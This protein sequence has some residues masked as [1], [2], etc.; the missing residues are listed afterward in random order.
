MKTIEVFLNFPI[1]DINRNAL[2][3]D[4][5]KVDPRQTQRLT[6]YWG[7]DTWR[8]EAYSGEGDLFGFEEK[9]TNEALASAFRQRLIS[10]ANFAYVPEPIPMRNSKGAVVYYLYFASQNRNGAKIV[11]AIFDKYRDRSS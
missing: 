2:W 5:G 10:V 9:T 3:R 11:K 6:R 8:S 4:R 1:M 7:D